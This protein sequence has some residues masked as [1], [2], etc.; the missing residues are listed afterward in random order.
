MTSNK[1]APV[2]S[3]IQFDKTDS[4]WNEVPKMGVEGLIATIDDKKELKRKLI[5]VMEDRKRLL[6]SPVATKC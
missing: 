3:I 4:L 2:T 1:K 6:R 5:Q